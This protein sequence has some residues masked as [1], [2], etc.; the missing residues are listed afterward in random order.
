MIFISFLLWGSVSCL[1]K[2]VFCTK[3]LFGFRSTD[4]GMH[5]CPFIFCL[6]KLVGVWLLLIF[7]TSLPKTTLSALPCDIHVW[8]I[9]D[10]V[11]VSC[12]ICR[13]NM[14]AISINFGKV[15]R[16]IFIGATI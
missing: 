14:S 12:N 7:V 15:T 5:N 2:H 11:L 16:C 3:I 8:F 4:R 9:G 13:V 1:C 10:Y 6:A